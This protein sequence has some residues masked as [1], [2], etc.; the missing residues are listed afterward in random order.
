MFTPLTN[1]P[2]SVPSC[3]PP[4]S[5]IWTSCEAPTAKRLNRY[6]AAVADV[7][8]GVEICVIGKE[9]DVRLVIELEK[10]FLTAKGVAE[11]DADGRRNAG[12]VIVDFTRRRE[13]DVVVVNLRDIQAECVM[14]T[15]DA[16]G[17]RGTGLDQVIR[18]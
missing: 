10:I 7:F 9:Q 13:R 2:L 12:V 3:G 16:F 18:R 4:V 17:N 15:P 8:N 6:C 11:A 1:V 14:Q 5:T